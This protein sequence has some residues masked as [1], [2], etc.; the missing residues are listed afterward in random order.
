MSDDP[1]QETSYH[2]VFS[3][4]DEREGDLDDVLEFVEEHF[5]M[6]DTLDPAG[7]D[8]RV[9]ITRTNRESEA[10]RERMKEAIDEQYPPGHLVTVNVATGGKIADAPDW[11]ELD[12]ELEEAN[13]KPNDVLTIRSQEDARR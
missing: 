11:H 6:L 9:K 12:K 8:T 3:D 4:G 5:D 13:Y 10:R 7:V 1:Q 2:A